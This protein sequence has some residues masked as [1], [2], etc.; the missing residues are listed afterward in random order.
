MRWLI[1]AL[2]T[3]T[4]GLCAGHPLKAEVVLN[5]QFTSPTGNGQS[6]AAVVG[7]SGDQWN[8]FT[9]NNF[10]V[11]PV[12]LINTSGGSSGVSLQATAGT[13]D[14]FYAHQGTTPNF[15][16]LINGY[17]YFT[18]SNS[19]SPNRLSLTGLN[20]SQLYDIYLYTQADVSGKVLSAKINSGTTQT[21]NAGSNTAA[22]YVL[23]QNYLVFSNVLATGGNLNIDYWS[24]SAGAPVNGIQI[25]AVPEP[26][27]LLLG[28]IGAACSGT[29]VWW[30][31]RKR[32]PQPETTEQPAAI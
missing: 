16:A 8:L 23:N 11:S 3:L 6:G 18:N 29:G 19:S 22:S 10:T 25:V 9:S 32:Q 5:V 12:A 15:S 30:K 4:L 31:R 7:T 17:M 27:T 13:I 21:T 24:A 26:G 14:G 20:S 1:A 28:G 2:T